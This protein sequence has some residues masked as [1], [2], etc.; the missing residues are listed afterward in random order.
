LTISETKLKYREIKPWRDSLLI[1]QEQCCALCGE[2]IDSDPVLDHCHTTGYVRGVLH[3]GCNALLGK[4]ER[5]LA[6][7]KI[8]PSRLKAICENLSEYTEHHHSVIHPTHKPKKT[9]KGRK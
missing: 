3:R 6:I 2:T 8:T 5:N 4:L 9:T 1:E 7:N